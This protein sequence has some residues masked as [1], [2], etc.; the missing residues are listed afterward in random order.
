MNGA[1]SLPPPPPP[2][3]CPRPHPPLQQQAPSTRSPT[4][5]H[6]TMCTHNYRLSKPR[7]RF[8]A[9]SFSS[10]NSIDKTSQSLSQS[11]RR[12]AHS[13]CFAMRR[14]PPAASTHN[15]T[16]SDSLS[17][18]QVAPVSRVRPCTSGPERASGRPRRRARVAVARARRGQG[19]AGRGAHEAR[20]ADHRHEGDN[21]ELSTTRRRSVPF[22]IAPPHAHA[23][24]IGHCAAC[25]VF[26][27]ALFAAQ[28]LK[29]SSHR[30]IAEVVSS[31]KNEVKQISEEKDQE[32]CV[33][34]QPHLPRA[35]AA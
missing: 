23:H 10:C 7:T 14:S 32:M 3:P 26:C 2:P 11:H 1:I 17:S 5:G 34:N 28:L 25:S 24:S 29:L 15:A 8:L 27:W 9:P 6:R 30:Q 19:R 4:H 12:A 31:W 13:L 18:A 16:E 35:A 33:A 20:R 22:L 21:T